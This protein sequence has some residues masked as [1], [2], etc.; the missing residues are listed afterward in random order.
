[1]TNITTGSSYDDD[2]DDEDD[3]LLIALL[4]HE[5]TRISMIAAARFA[6]NNYDELVSSR[7][8]IISLI[9]RGDS[10]TLFEDAPVEGHRTQ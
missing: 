1:M 2:R 6:C 8:S 10:G 9:E 5:S 7:L 4:A 3:D